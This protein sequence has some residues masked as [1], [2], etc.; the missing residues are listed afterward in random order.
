[1]RND[2]SRPSVRAR[3]LAEPRGVN[4]LDFVGDR[5]VPELED[6]DAAVVVPCRKDRA[7]GRVTRCERHVE[8][9]GVEGVDHALDDVA[10]ARLEHCVHQRARRPFDEGLFVV[11]TAEVDVLFDEHV[12]QLSGGSEAGGVGLLRRDALELL[13]DLVMTLS[14]FA[15]AAVAPRGR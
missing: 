12:D 9:P 10:V 14:G 15:T 11:D 7:L 13:G 6:A 4:L 5:E 8:R 2:S 3:A 1:M